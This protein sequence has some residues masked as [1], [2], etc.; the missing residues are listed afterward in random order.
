MT[1]HRCHHEGR[2]LIPPSPE[3]REELKAE[4]AR[5]N[6]EAALIGPALRIAEP[7]R[8]GYND[9]LIVPGDHFDVGTPLERVR[10]EAAVRAPLRG[11]VRV[12]VV[13]V[14][15]EDQP[16]DA[17]YDRRHYE[18]LFFSMGMVPTGSVREYF[19]EVSA[20]L[21][22]IQGEVVGPLRMPRTLRDYANNESGVGSV[23][24]NARTLARDAAEA[25]NPHVNFGPYDND[26]NGY[27][28]A[29]VVL[30]SGS[31]AE[32]TGSRHHIWS[33]KWVLSG[34]DF[35]ADGT[36][37]YAYLTV[38]ADARIGVCC[39]EL[40]HLLF[41]WPDLYDTDGSSEGV[42]NWCLMAGGSWN[43]GGDTPAHPS[44]WC[45]VRQGWVQLVNQ[46]A[47]AVV[48]VPDVKDGHTVYRLW[49]QGAQ[50]DE[51]FLLENRQQSRF[52]RLLPGQGILIYH[53]DD[54]IATNADERHPKVALLQA[55]G[56]EHLN[57]AINR[58]DAGDAF[59]GT[60][61]NRTFTAQSSPS[62][63]AYGGLDSGV[64]VTE[65]SDAGATMSAR[66][67][68]RPLVIR[69]P[70]VLPRGL[71]RW[72]GL[73]LAPARAG[74]ATGRLP[75]LRAYHRMIEEMYGTEEGAGGYV[76]E[77]DG[78]WA[79]MVDERLDSI[80]QTLE[81]IRGAL[82]EGQLAGHDAGMADEEPLPR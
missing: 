3:L 5:I 58:G 27:V 65:I 78:E 20:G 44:A 71:R 48:T 10:S 32:T 4:L 54:A 49:K 80:E 50:G 81:L 63:R 29:F 7:R 1:V 51:Y 57:R 6:A 33:H 61:N 37:I 69:R 34:G 18:D 46:T 67:T 53:V 31:G 22:D 73:P 72:L 25:A 43:G 52:D 30:H 56:A 62:S 14:D 82:L 39:H 38:P 36:R 15:F 21:V 2:C 70:Y 66:M 23:Q 41:G 35:H 9:G 8:P 26:G 76:T 16:L 68:V 24:P 17:R 74:R 40:G 45:K 13:L 77:P 59:P 47:N 12:V 75:Q 79:E 11:T 42:G 55:D 19:R 28:D 60:A 64:M